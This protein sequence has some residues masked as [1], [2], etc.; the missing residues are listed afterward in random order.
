MRIN[1]N[2]NNNDNKKNT[3]TNYSTNRSH[4]GGWWGNHLAQG[5]AAFVRRRRMAKTS[6][7]RLPFGSLARDK[8][9]LDLPEIEERD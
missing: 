9:S 1:G 3:R 5:T 7:A 2:N 4:W 6:P 8:P